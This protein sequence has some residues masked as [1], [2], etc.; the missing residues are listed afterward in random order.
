MPDR[1]RK[2]EE[3]RESGR[4]GGGAG[5]KDEVGR[6]GVYPASGPHPSG[7]APIVEQGAWGQGARGIEG[8]QDHG[9][10]ELS[11]PRV[12]P[13]RAR[14]L[15]T[16]NPACCLTS[17]TAAAAAQ[18]M[19]EHDTGVL[20]VVDSHRNKKLL[21]V[22]TDRDLALQVVAE[23]RDPLATAVAETM[24]QPIIVCS[25]DDPY[26]RA[27]E[28]MEQHR[29]RRIPVVD[30]A[31]SVVGI[32]AQADIALRAGDKG[33]TAQVVAQISQPKAR[34]GGGGAR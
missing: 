32:I 20:P 12:T 29:V 28:L 24:S 31:G 21:G 1:N 19:M 25:P 7:D 8:Y 17:A 26:E 5:R 23:G 10:S 27:L 9:E 30:D 13:E 11:V 6:S 34:H 2:R 3:E 4:P 22:V 14:D 18:L 16:K 33:K 15:M